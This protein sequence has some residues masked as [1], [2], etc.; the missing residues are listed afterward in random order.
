MAT[1]TI[2][3]EWPPNKVNSYI[4]LSMKHHKIQEALP[5]DKDKVIANGEINNGSNEARVTKN[6]MDIFVANP[7]NEAMSNGIPPRSI[8][9]EGAPGIGKTV[10]LKEI[11]YCWA[12][13][14]ILLKDAKIVFHLY[15]RDQ[16][17]Q[18]ITKIK[19]LL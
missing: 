19:E 1:R 12:N 16:K 6:I 18:A 9:I 7:F 10:L 4:D 17:F 8:L 11:A 14:T 15:L 3:E 13:G 5:V 2:S